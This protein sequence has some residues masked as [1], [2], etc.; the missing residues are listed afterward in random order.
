MGGSWHGHER[1]VRQVHSGTRISRSGIEGKIRFEGWCRRPIGIE[2]AQLRR[3]LGFELQGGPDRVEVR[4]RATARPQSEARALPCGSAARLSRTSVTG[5][6]RER[7]SS[8]P[9]RNPSSLRGSRSG[10]EQA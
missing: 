3:R 5:S 4:K 10:R 7:R 8:S 9:N 1:A 2:G 6:K